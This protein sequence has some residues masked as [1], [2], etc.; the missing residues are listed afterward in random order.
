MSQAADEVIVVAT[1]VPKPEH[2]DEVRA[3]FTRAIARTHAED[4][5]CLLFAL[6]ESDA[7]F[8]MIEK[9]AT[10]KDLEAHGS[11]PAIK[12]LGPAL[13]TGLAAAPNVQVFKAVPAGTETQGRV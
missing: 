11:G 5:G 13:R 1:I 4:Q 6:H 7:G 3:A 9:W 8:C 10:A 2:R 12:E